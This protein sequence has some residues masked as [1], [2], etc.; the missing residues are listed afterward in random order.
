MFMQKGEIKVLTFNFSKLVKKK[1]RIKRS[2]LLVNLLKERAKRVARVEKIKM[3]KA[4]N[5]LIWKS[6]AKNPPTRIRVKL[7]KEN[8]YATLERV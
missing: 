7:A 5:E 3:S 1:T 8:D 2:K 6:G 4:L